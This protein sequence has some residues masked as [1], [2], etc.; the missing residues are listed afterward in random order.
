M[1]DISALR[2]G[3]ALI[4]SRGNYNQWRSRSAGFPESAAKKIPMLFV[5]APRRGAPGSRRQV[6]FGHDLLGIQPFFR[7]AESASGL[8]VRVHFPPNLTR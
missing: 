6:R 1:V 4:R 5:S 3:V 7:R 2:V 8:E